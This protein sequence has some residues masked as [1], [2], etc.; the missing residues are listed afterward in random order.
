[1][2]ETR[3]TLLL[4]PANVQHA[5]T[6][7]LALANQLPLNPATVPGIPDGSAFMLPALG[8]PWARCAE[9]MEHP[10]TR[11]LRPLVFDAALAAG[12]DDVV[13]AH[14]GHRLVSMSLRLL[15]AQ[16]W[17]AEADRKLYRASTRIVPAGYLSDPVVVAHGRI[18]VLGQTNHRI[19]EELIMAGGRV[20]EGRFARIPVQE[21][22]KLWQLAM[23]EE[24]TPAAAAEA[25]LVN[26]WPTI[27][28]SLLNALD[29]RKDDR[30]QTLEN[31]L[32]KQADEEVARFSAV[33]RELEQTIRKEL[34]TTS[35][36]LSFFSDEEREQYETD[37]SMLKHRLSQIP[38]ER[39]AEIAQLKARYAAPRAN[40]FPVAVTWLIPSHLAGGR[41]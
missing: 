30:L 18:V 34:G 26:L 37:L 12:R 40:L 4:S 24:A 11:E 7:A 13:L 8:G 20:R 23:Q 9:G 16:I 1:M 38:A 31:R 17:S 2:D 21:L 33:M 29:A 15:R 6:V 28:G 5:V 32:T 39:D 27:R 19:F 10:H 41:S 35:Y 25:R 22:E 14:L 3:Q 36:Q